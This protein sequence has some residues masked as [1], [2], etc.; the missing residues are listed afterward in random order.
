[1]TSVS[2]QII[3]L[4]NCSIPKR[5]VHL[6]H[7]ATKLIFLTKLAVECSSGYHIMN[8]VHLY[9]LLSGTPEKDYKTLFPNG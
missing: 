3:G 7:L 2:E 9:F 6:L 8:N 4:S 1:M 5:K